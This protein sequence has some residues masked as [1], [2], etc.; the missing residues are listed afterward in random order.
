MLATD[1]FETSASGARSERFDS[2]VPQHD[3]DSAITRQVPACPSRN[4][5]RVEGR[6]VRGVGRRELEPVH[7]RRHDRTRDL[8][9]VG[10]N[11]RGRE[12]GDNGSDGVPVE[13]QDHP[14]LGR[15]FKRIEPDNQSMVRCRQHRNVNGGRLPAAEPCDHVA[16]S[17]WAIP[18]AT[19][20]NSISFTGHNRN[21]I[22]RTEI[23]THPP[24]RQQLQRRPNG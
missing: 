23:F 3:R 11:T 9:A 22:T 8:E 2:H 20:E 1:L 12:S 16:V 15:A 21:G 4:L 13:P 6:E 18:P 24:I 19:K 5:P 10:S 17:R 7:P 14:L